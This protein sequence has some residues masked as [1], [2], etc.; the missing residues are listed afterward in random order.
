[1]SFD[2]DRL[3]DDESSYRIEAYPGEEI[4]F[5]FASMDKSW[6]IT[7]KVIGLESPVV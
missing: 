1:M 4:G 5:L 2:I 7:N 6:I 3:A